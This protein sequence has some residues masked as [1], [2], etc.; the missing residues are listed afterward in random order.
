MA[1]TRALSDEGRVRILRALCAGELCVCQIV[2]LL[3]LA[4]STISKHLGLLRGAGLIESRKDGRWIYYRL[5]DEEADPAV[6]GALALVREALADDPQVRADEQRL[7]AILRIDPEVLCCRLREEPL[8]QR[9]ARARAGDEGPTARKRSAAPR[10]PRAS[11]KGA[12]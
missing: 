12:R 3:A 1:V 9:R 8:P 6:R 11:R 5:A 4:P 7:R 2:E 10:A